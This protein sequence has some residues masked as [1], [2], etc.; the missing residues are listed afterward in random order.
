MMFWLLLQWW[1]FETMRLSSRKFLGSFCRTIDGQTAPTLTLVTD[2]DYE[3]E[4]S[5]NP[6]LLKSGYRVAIQ[7]S[8]ADTLTIV[9]QTQTVFKSGLVDGKWFVLKSGDAKDGMVR[10][11]CLVRA[12]ICGRYSYP[13]IK[14]EISDDLGFFRCQQFV[15]LRQTLTVLPFLIRPQS[16]V[17]V[18]K[19]NN[20]QQHLGHHRYVL[21]RAD[22]GDPQHRA[23]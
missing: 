13:G 12:P 4:L 15:P 18:L 11:R 21:V 9:G 23:G 7:D 2:R 6:S 1:A 22:H 20:L 14:V 17:S 16:T 8:V 3:V 5:F 19:H 10:L